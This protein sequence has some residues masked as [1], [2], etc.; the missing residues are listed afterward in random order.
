[1]LLLLSG[2]PGRQ[3]FSNRERFGVKRN[4]FFFLLE[5]LTRENVVCHVT[6]CFGEQLETKLAAH[7]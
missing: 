6:L 1:M 7:P 3:I 4:Y 5:Q 2:V